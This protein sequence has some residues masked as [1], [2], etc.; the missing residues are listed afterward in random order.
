M[1]PISISGS[2][3]ATHISVSSHRGVT[4]AEPSYLFFAWESLRHLRCEDCVTT[5]DYVTRFRL[6]VQ[7][8][9]NLGLDLDGFFL[10]KESSLT[11]LNA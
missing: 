8:L 4:L 10:C 5:T 1:R 7:R 3:S 6:A 9:R 2:A 11:Y